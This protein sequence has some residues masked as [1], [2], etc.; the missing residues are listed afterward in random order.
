MSEHRSRLPGL[1][2][3][4]R[5]WTFGAACVAFAGA[6]GPCNAQ[7]PG[8][9]VA[10]QVRTQGYQC[11]DPVSATRDTDL[12]KPDLAVWNLK[13]KNASYRVM[14]VP[15]MAARITKLDANSK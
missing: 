2:R 14:L 13:C 5:Q 6:L 11:D 10:T 15:D 4:V 12:S 8:E 9:A 1:S 7:T 3:R